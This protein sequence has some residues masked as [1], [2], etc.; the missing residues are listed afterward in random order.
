MT[1]AEFLAVLSENV[2]LAGGLFR[3]FITARGLD[4]GH[5]IVR[6]GTPGL[7]P[8]GSMPRPLGSWPSPGEL[9]AVD[10]LLVLQSSPLLAHAT[11]AQLW[12]LSQIARPVTLPVGAEALKA[13]AEPAMLFV[14]AGTLRVD[15]DTAGPGDVIGVHETLAGSRL[16]ATV[17]VIEPATV[18]R[19]DRGELFELLADH[20]DLLQGLFSKLVRR[21]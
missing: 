19:V 21:P 12:S 17:S 18:L 13:D 3:Q 16:G 6:G 2:E 4:S 20:T 1:P 8:G 5:A 9:R 11:A 7:K 15:G 10:R 14:V